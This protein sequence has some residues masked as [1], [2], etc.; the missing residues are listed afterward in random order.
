MASPADEEME[1][2]PSAAAPPVVASPT[3]AGAAAG[4]G[5]KAPE[6]SILPECTPS[7]SASGAVMYEEDSE[8]DRSRIPPGDK[9]ID[10]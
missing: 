5:G 8:T 3:G 9:R 2:P 6:A 7:L 10:Q 4:P 1:S